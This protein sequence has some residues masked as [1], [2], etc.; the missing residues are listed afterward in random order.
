MLVAPCPVGLLII[1]SQSGK[2]LI[3]AV[4]LFCPTTI[5]PIFTVIPTMIIVVF[6][7]VVNPIV[8][9]QRCGRHCY[10]NYQGGPE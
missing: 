6:S 5:R 1:L 4:V 7:V 8:G 3:F 2:I 9:T 10:G